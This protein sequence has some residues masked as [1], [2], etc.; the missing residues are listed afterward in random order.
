MA[1]RVHARGLADLIGTGAEL[2]AS[3]D[4]L[5]LA[6]QAAILQ[7]LI[8]HV[9]ILPGVSGARSLDP[10]RVQPVWIV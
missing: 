3:W 6:R 5:N 8:D 4:T 7:T 10:N 2:R 9:V 1:E